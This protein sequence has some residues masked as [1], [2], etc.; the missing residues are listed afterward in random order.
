MNQEPNQT[1]IDWGRI[2]S[3][4]DMAVSD[5]AECIDCQGAIPRGALFRLVPDPNPD[6]AHCGTIQCGECAAKELL[7]IWDAEHPEAKR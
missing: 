2:R 5:G 6:L 1:M 4:F 3:Q 7:P